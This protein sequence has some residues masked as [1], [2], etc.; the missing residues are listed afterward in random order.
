[1]EIGISPEDAAHAPDQGNN[2]SLV[3]LGDFVHNPLLSADSKDALRAFIQHGR[4]HKEEATRLFNF[5]HSPDFSWFD[6]EDSTSTSNNA[7]LRPMEPCDS[8]HMSASSSSS[9]ENPP[10]Q[11]QTPTLT[12]NSSIGLEYHLPDDG[13]VAL[14]TFLLWLLGSQPR[15]IPHKHVKKLYD[16]SRLHGHGTDE[17]FQALIDAADS[18]S[19]KTEPATPIAAPRITAELKSPNSDSPP[20]EQQSVFPQGLFPLS[21]QQGHLLQPYQHSHGNLLVHQARVDHS[22]SLI[23]PFHYGALMQSAPVP[24]TL[25][26]GSASAQQFVA[27]AALSRMDGNYS[28][29]SPATMSQP[30]MLL[31]DSGNRD[32]ATSPAAQPSVVESPPAIMAPQS[33]RQSGGLQS[34]TAHVSPQSPGT[35]TSSASA[36]DSSNKTKLTCPIAKDCGKVV[37]ADNSTNA[38]KFLIE[39]IRRVHPDN[40]IQHLPSTKES[41]EKMVNMEVAV[42]TLLEN[43][44]QCDFRL[45]GQKGQRSPWRQALDHVREAHP[46][47]YISDLPANKSSFV[48]SKLF[49]PVC[50]VVE[51]SRVKCL[52]LRGPIPSP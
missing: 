32:I 34:I 3:G 37:E 51:R 12:N 39:H 44:Q 45:A 29:I 19:K 49:D 50:L 13:D 6:D 18:S 28:L 46:K 16:M 23:S 31:G 40:H 42:C 24:V 52:E 15:R 38:F 47:D 9:S 14:E 48:A 25:Q 7:A 10:T 33:S 21:Y 20:V 11:P 41:V 8:T 17:G 26:Q 5:C 43:G 1:M 36:G 35:A 2:G 4:T 30:S 22:R 27:P